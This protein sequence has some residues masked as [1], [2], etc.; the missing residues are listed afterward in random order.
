ME[1]K[2]CIV[3]GIALTGSKKKF[4]SINC[5]QKYYYNQTKVNPNSYFTQTIRGYRRKLKLIDLKGGKCEI[6]GYNKNIAALE[7]HHIDSSQKNFSLD[8]RKL[9]NSKWD[10]LIKEVSKCMLLC[11]N[12]HRE[13]HNPEYSKEYIESL[14]IKSEITELHKDEN[15][16]TKECKYCG[17]SMLKTNHH[18]YCS[19]KCKNLSKQQ[20]FNKYPTFEEINCKYQ[21]LKSWQRVADYFNITRKIVQGIRKR[22]NLK[23]IGSNPVGPTN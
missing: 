21:E 17:K 23:I 5:K 12:C 13:I 10:G 2:Y 1:K 3:C 9:S 19:E 4:C 20:N 7:F 15:F 14:K 22:K 18:Y 16:S 6:C 11:S 8:I